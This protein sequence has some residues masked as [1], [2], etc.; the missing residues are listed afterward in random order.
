MVH[1]YVYPRCFSS[2]HQRFIFVSFEKLR[3]FCTL[4]LNYSDD[5]LEAKNLVWSSVIP[6]FVVIHLSGID[7]KSRTYILTK[8]WEL[9]LVIILPSPSSYLRM[10]KPIIVLRQ[11]PFRGFLVRKVPNVDASFFRYYTTLKLLFILYFITNC[12]LHINFWCIKTLRF[13]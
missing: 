12:L 6:K 13:M 2:S 9:G 10:D 3:N 11:E 4:I 1:A 5:P 8:T 7:I